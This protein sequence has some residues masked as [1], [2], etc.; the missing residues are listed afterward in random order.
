MGRGGW[1]GGEQEGGWV[2]GD[3]EGKVGGGQGGVGRRDSLS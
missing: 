1:L 2:G 3:F